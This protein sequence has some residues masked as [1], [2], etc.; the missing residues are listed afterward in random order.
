MVWLKFLGSC[1]ISLVL[2]CGCFGTAISWWCRH[3][4][5]RELVSRDI[6]LGRVGVFSDSLEA[7]GCLSNYG[8][9]S[10]P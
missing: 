5:Y 7:E 9:R 2:G 1:S 8:I 3:L 6:F 10:G 4:E